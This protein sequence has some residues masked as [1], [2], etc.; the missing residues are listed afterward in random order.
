MSLHLSPS[1][2]LSREIRA[3]NLSGGPTSGGGRRAKGEHKNLLLNKCK[4]RHLQVP[5][6]LLNSN[7]REEAGWVALALA[8]KGFTTFIILYKRMG[9]W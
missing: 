7:L 2:I 3:R 9:P 8:H 6:N 1:A 5:N 4:K